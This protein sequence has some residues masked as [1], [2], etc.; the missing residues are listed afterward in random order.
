MA[1][2][3]ITYCDEIA[4]DGETGRGLHAMRLSGNAFTVDIRTPEGRMAARAWAYDW[5]SLAPE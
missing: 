2:D 3:K 1:G 5:A 4:V